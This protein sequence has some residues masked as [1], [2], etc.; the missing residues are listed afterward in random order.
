MNIESSHRDGS[1]AVRND[2]IAEYYDDR[3]GYVL[4]EEGH[5]VPYDKKATERLTRAMK[6]VAAIA[7]RLE[8]L[9]PR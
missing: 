5:V 3:L 8:K 6:D 9:E 1:R 2:D 4:N 7:R